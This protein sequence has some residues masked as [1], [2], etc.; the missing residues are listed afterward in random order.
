VARHAQRAGQRLHVRQQLDARFGPRLYTDG[1]RIYTTLDLEVQQSAER[2]LDAQLN[3]I[4]AGTYGP[5]KHLTYAAYL[6]QQAESDDNLE[7][8]TTPYLQG[9]AVTLEARTGRI[10][11]MVGGRDYND[12]KFNGRDREDRGR[13]SALDGVD[14]SH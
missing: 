9:L 4:E 2:A 10:L 11:A 5:Y 8:P 13:D 14:H 3:A 1:L 7:H 12:S 6:E